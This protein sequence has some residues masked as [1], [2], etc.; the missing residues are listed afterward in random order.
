MK[1]KM[2][3]LADR[4]LKFSLCKTEWG[5]KAAF[6]R[7]EEEED[8]LVEATYDQNDEVRSLWILYFMDKRYQR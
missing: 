8:R 4:W 6:K 3:I 7:Y 5:R 1:P 2:T